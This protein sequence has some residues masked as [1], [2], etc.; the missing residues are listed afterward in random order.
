MCCNWNVR[1]AMSQQVSRV[2][3]FC[4]NTCLHFFN[5][6]QSHR[7]PQCVEI[8]PMS[9]QTAAASLNMSYFVH[10]NTCVPQMH[11]RLTRGLLMT[12]Q[13]EMFLNAMLHDCSVENLKR[14][15]HS[16]RHT[17]TRLMALFQDY[18]GEPVPER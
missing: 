11:Q 10:I 17:H 1:Q 2:T 12:R 18:P 7:T 4:V 6:D 8:Q 15:L 16:S 9:Q 5:I 14:S 3:T 13:T